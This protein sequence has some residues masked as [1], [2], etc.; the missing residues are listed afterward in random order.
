MARYRKTSMV[1]AIA[2]A[3]CLTACG[4]GGGGV[5]SIPPPPVTPPPPPPPP[6]LPIE[7]A[8]QA[9]LPAANLFPQAQA[10]GPT[11]Q[12]HAL[13]NFPL[14]ESVVTIDATGVGPDD[15]AMSTGADL[16]FEATGHADD[17]YSLS[18]P[19]AGLSHVDLTAGGFYCYGDL[20]GAA[21][22]QYV[23]VT[24]ADPATSDLSWTTYGFWDAYRVFRDA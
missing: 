7:A 22:G 6:P 17:E 5:G 9:V 19:G 16:D 10:G 24:I 11:I 20:C 12:D 21:N 2:L 18:V 23:E 15:G 1:S 3:V 13:T 8:A 4:G 14:I